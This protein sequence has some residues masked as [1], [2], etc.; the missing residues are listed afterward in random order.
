MNPTTSS[1][2]S[3]S[4]SVTVISDACSRGIPVGRRSA[5]REVLR[6]SRRARLAGGCGSLSLSRGL[7]VAERADEPARLG[8]VEHDRQGRAVLVGAEPEQRGRRSGAA[9]VWAVLVG[10]DD[11]RRA[12]L[13]GEC[14]EGASCLGALLE[15]ARVVAEEDV[16]LVAAGEALERSP[17]AGGGMPVASGSDGKGAAVGEAAQVAEPEACSGRQVVQTETERHRPGGGAAGPGA[18]ERIGV[19]VVALHEQKL[20]AGTAKQ[21]SGGAEETTPFRVA[22]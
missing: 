9:D 1:S 16:D 20:E 10:V 3:E 5:R 17:F 15:R 7:P 13:R 19:V 12:E 8:A 4:S 14:G 6:R 22:R 2:A 21:G 11:E 18:R